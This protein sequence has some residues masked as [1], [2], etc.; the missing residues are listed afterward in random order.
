MKTKNQLFSHLL[1]AVC[2]ILVII[3][4]QWTKNLVV[5]RLSPPDSGKLVPLVGDYLSLYYIQNWN[6]AMGLFSNPI[7]LT[8][9]IAVALIVLLYLYIRWFSRGPAIYKILFGL[10][11]GG[12]IGN[13]MDRFIRGGYVVDFIY[14]R[15]PQL[16]FKFY[17]FNVADAAISVAVLLLFVLLLFSD[18]RQ[19]RKPEPVMSDAQAADT[20]R[21]KPS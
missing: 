15:I 17:I 7:L 13:L 14:F 1:A 16:N 20:S 8:V 12:A 4:D 5:A 10:I 6:S 18:I 2:A 3:V 9:L 11:L 21:S 19:A